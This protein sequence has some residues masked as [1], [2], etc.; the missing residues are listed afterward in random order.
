MKLAYLAL[1][2]ALTFCLAGSLAGQQP[3]AKKRVLFIGE[4]Q[5]FQHDSVSYAAGTIWKLGHDTGL[6]ETYIRTDT[7]LVTKKRL[8]LNAKNLG[9]FDAVIFYTSGELPM[10]DSQRADLLSFVRD[11]GRGFI[12]AHSGNDTFYKWGEYGDMV[13]GYFDQHPWGTFDAP[14]VVEDASFPGM[15]YLPGAFTMRDEIYQSRDFSRG[16]VRVLLRLDENQLDYSVQN[17]HRTDR[18]FAVIW[19]RNYGKGRVLYNGLGHVEAVWDRPDIQKMW[20]EH[21]KWVLGLI[22][23]DA[24]PRPKPGN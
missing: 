18:D 17:I 5:G 12:A 10:D 20:I 3:P 7:Q 24:T 23:G 14:F 15:Q 21:M 6:W 9:Y 16:K 8:G 1:A 19:A 11:D 4:S 22:P 2:A 13:G